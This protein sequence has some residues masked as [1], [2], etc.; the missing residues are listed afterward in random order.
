M[1]KCCGGSTSAELFAVFASH[2]LPQESLMYFDSLASNKFPQ[3][4]LTCL[5]TEEILHFMDAM[6]EETHQ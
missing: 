6:I 2:L 3:E 5:H 4:N 1:T